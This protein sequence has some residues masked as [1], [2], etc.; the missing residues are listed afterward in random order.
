MD[1]CRLS[2]TLIKDTNPIITF[3]DRIRILSIGSITCWV[4]QFRAL[5][6]GCRWNRSEHENLVNSSVE[7][8][9]LGQKQSA[10][11]LSSIHRT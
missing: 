3:L 7:L 5:W 6:L 11:S 2:E 1:I 10:E 4:I 8:S 9:C